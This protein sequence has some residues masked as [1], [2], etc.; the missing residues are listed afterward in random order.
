MKTLQ[1]IL[2]Q[3][4]FKDEILIVFSTGKINTINTVSVYT[5]LIE[6]PT[7]KCYL[8]EN[9][10]FLFLLLYKLT[11][12]LCYRSKYLCIESK[13]KSIKTFHRTSVISVNCKSFIE[14][15]SVA[16]PQPRRATE[17]LQCFVH[18]DQWNNFKIE[19]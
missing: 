8:I 17:Y 10:P 12:M 1:R 9:I 19:A 2:I 15:C 11:L 5:M 3:F 14:I 13:L 4:Y 7:Y 6:L 16:Y 18:P